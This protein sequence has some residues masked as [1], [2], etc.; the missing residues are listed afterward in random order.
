MK[1]ST[2]SAEEDVHVSS[3]PVFVRMLSQRLGDDW[4]LRGRSRTGS[5][6]C[7]CQKFGQGKDGW[8]ETA[9]QGRNSDR[10]GASV[11]KQ[12]VYYIKWLARLMH[13]YARSTWQFSDI[14][15]G[16]GHDRP[17]TLV[18]IRPV[19]ARERASDSKFYPFGIAAKPTCYL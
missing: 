10:N 7:W 11:C 16:I 17:L 13:E 8:E 2:P 4:G 5:V 6:G 3:P 1:L 9:F 14:Q 15:C 12:P 18:S 19:Q